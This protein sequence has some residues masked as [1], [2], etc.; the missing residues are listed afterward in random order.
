MSDCTVRARGAHIVDASGERTNSSSISISAVVVRPL[1]TLTRGQK[2]ASANHV[3]Q[4]QPFHDHIARL[5]TGSSLVCVAGCENV[6]SRAG[7]TWRA[8]QQP[9]GDPL[10]FYRSGAGVSMTAESRTGDSIAGD[11]VFG[12]RNLLG[13]QCGHRIDVKRAVGRR[14]HPGNSGRQ[15]QERDGG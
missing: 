7:P 9:A 11:W 2:V 10:F 12:A 5:A 6:A 14:E 3:R 4:L 1:T 15:Q 8:L 13:S